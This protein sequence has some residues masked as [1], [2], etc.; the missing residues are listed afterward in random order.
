MGRTPYVE[1]AKALYLTLFALVKIKP[2]SNY[3]IQGSHFYKN[4]LRRILTRI[5]ADLWAAS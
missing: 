2:I 1:G 5:H 3:S 4:L